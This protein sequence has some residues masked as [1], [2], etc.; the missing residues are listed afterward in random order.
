MY[1]MQ[2]CILML[3]DQLGVLFSGTVNIAITSNAEQSPS[4]SRALRLL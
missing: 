1:V 2:C 3:C 4:Q